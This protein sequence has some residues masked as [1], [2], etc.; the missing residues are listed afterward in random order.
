MQ[1]IQFVQSDHR[2]YIKF[3]PQLETCNDK[4]FWLACDSATGAE[5]MAI[6]LNKIIQ[7][8]IKKTRKTEY[9]KG[10][11]AGRGHKTKETWFDPWHLEKV[12]TVS[13]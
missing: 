3:N 10:Y 11:K 2:V 13:N 5:L 4:A 8:A 6:R 12:K 1:I 7:L 9:E